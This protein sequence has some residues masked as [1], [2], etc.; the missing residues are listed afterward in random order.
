MAELLKNK[1]LDINSEL[2]N[3]YFDINGIKNYQEI[4]IIN[5]ENEKEILMGYP[6]ILIIQNEIKSLND[7]MPFYTAISYIKKSNSIY[8]KEQINLLNDSSIKEEIKNYK[9]TIIVNSDNQSYLISLNIL[10][11]E[12]KLSEKEYLKID[13]YGCIARIKL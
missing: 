11:E 9:G 5:K 13:K 7:E 1:N 2:F 6:E 8:L 4:L 3:N 10:T 12:Y